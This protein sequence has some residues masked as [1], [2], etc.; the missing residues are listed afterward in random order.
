MQGE[1]LERGLQLAAV[2]HR[3]QLRKITGIPYLVH[4]LAVAIILAQ[5]GC[6]EEVLVAAMLHDAIEDTEC[7][8]QDLLR[9]F[10]AHVVSWVI[11]MSEVKKSAAGDKYIWS[12]RKKE[13]LSRIKLAPWQSQAI[14]IADKIHNVRSMLHDLSQGHPIWDHFP[15]G[16]TRVLW[17]YTTALENVNREVQI[18]NELCQILEKLIPQLAT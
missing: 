8:Q 15:A 14:F 12:D 2:L 17:Y 16:K 13:H 10:P 6:P 5:R 9:M 7:T 18:V 3:E 11:D 4:P 1:I